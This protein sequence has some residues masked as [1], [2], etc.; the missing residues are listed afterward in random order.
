M[1]VWEWTAYRGERFVSRGDPVD[2]DAVW[3]RL[4]ED[5][6]ARRGDV[7]AAHRLFLLDAAMECGQEARVAEYLGPSPPLRDPSPRFAGRR[8]G[9]IIYRFPRDYGDRLNLLQLAQPIRQARV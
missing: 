7:E 5:F 8:D 9:R 3:E 6:I 1:A 4:V 2:V